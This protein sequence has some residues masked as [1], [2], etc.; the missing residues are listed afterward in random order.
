MKKFFTLSLLF[1][2][3]VIV[4]CHRGEKHAQEFLN[5]AIDGLSH[6]SVCLD[7]RGNKS[8]HN[9]VDKDAHGKKCRGTRVELKKFTVVDESSE[10]DHD[11]VVL[12]FWGETKR[13]IKTR[14]RCRVSVD[15]ADSD[16]CY[17]T[18]YEIVKEWKYVGIKLDG[19]RVDELELKEGKHL[20][21]AFINLIEHGFNKF[22]FLRYEPAADEFTFFNHNTLRSE[23]FSEN[24]TALKDLE[25]MGARVEDHNAN[26]LGEKLA[27]EYGLSEER[28]QVVAK[29]VSAYNKLITKRALTPS[30]QDQF[31]N[32][33]LGV[34]YKTAK[35]GVMS[36]D[37]DEFDSLMERA[38][39]T[40]GTSPEAMTAIIKDMIL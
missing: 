13:E 7:F 3:L 20:G 39:E 37:A 29:T 16:Y 25:L 22:T 8:V 31:S 38:A 28:G 23:I 36:G 5:G 30:E 9:G 21:Y 19:D 32:T 18:S 26:L 34:D 15:T 17:K 40:N 12:K 4:G 35:R 33:L 1:S 6:G 24:I 14:H 2:S 10:E 27:A 11:R